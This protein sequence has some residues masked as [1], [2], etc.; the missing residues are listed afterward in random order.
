MAAALLVDHH[1]DQKRREGP[2]ALDQFTALFEDVVLAVA[3]A[4]PSVVPVLD[5]A[6]LV[7]VGDRFDGLVERQVDVQ[8]LAPGSVVEAHDCRR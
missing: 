6:E 2:A 8:E 4:R 5:D 3:L 1:G 7:L